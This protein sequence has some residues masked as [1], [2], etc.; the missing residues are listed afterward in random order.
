MA[1][2]MSVTLVHRAE[3][4]GRNEMPFGWDTHVAPSNIVLGTGSG[5]PTERGDL[6]VRTGPPVPMTNRQPADRRR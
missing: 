4:V 6:G 1:I 3:A 2:C 5:L